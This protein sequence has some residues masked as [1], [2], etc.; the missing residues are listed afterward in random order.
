MDLPQELVDTILDILHDD[1][2]SLKSCSLAARIFVISARKHRFKKIEILSSSDASQRF[3]EL[4]CSSPHIAPLVEDLCIISVLET[5]PETCA[6]LDPSG[7]YMS[8]RTLSLILPLLTELKRISIIENRDVNHRTGLQYSRSWNKMEPPL[9][10]ALANVFSSPRL[11]AVHLCGLVLESPCHLLSLFS[12]ATALKKMSLSRL[13]FAQPQDRR[14]P[15][16][17]SQLWR[18][19][20]QSLLL[21]VFSTDLCQY[22]VNPQIDLTHVR[23]LR[24]ATPSPEQRKRMV[25][26][27][28]LRHSR[29]VEHLGLYLAYNFEPTLLSPELYSTNLRSI[30]FI[31]HS[32]VELLGIFVKTCPHDSRL[33]YITLDSFTNLQQHT[34][35]PKLYNAIDATVD[36]LPALKTIE[37][38]WI[39]SYPSD[40]FP[41]WEADA[42]TAFSSLM[43][44]GILRMTKLQLGQGSLL[45][46]G[47]E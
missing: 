5:F 11:E 28:S 17:E 18:P 40:V 33:E 36:H 45:P 10:S 25:L 35:V 46:I 34:D 38:R 3:Y 47:W 1:G 41:Q 9:Q 23:T 32:M 27:T 42:H 16:P 4:L 31:S 44:R 26:A 20:L 39:M 37:M 12:E 30:H 43:R 19:K 29:G 8:G 2:P 13:Y 6:Y 21:N 15:W 24:L 7:D 14:E 22:L